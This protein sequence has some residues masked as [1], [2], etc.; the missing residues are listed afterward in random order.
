MA[1][2]GS[3][4]GGA[5]AALAVSLLLAMAVSPRPVDAQPPADLQQSLRASR[6]LAAELGL[7]LS[8]AHGA[9]RAARPE[10]RDG[11]DS[12]LPGGGAGATPAAAGGLEDA[13]CA[14]LGEDVWRSPDDGRD[15]ASSPATCSPETLASAEW[16]D[17]VERQ[18][19][20]QQAFDLAPDLYTE[21]VDDL[22]TDVFVT[23][24]CPNDCDDAD[25]LR[26]W[27]DEH[28]AKALAL[29]DRLGRGAI[30]LS[31]S[32]PEIVTKNSQDTTIRGLQ[33]IMQREEGRLMV[34]YLSE[35]DPGRFGVLQPPSEAERVF[36]A[37]KKIPAWIQNETSRRMSRRIEEMSAEAPGVVLL[38]EALESLP[39]EASAV[40][41]LGTTFW[42]RSGPAAVIPCK[43]L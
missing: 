6:V 21:A 7:V 24:V 43:R 5:R 3:S 25:T 14:I 16:Q 34:R 33:F 10:L 19:G 29:L 9:T 2:Y 38:Q 15:P 4:E 12:E 42:P 30:S 32:L 36:R 26:R 39:E 23:V 22:L 8:G 11:P 13:F 41:H 20:L 17:V 31:I 37:I 35:V 27:W 1:T 40:E 18:T 28:G